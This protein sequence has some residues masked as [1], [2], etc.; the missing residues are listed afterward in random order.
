MLYSS[1]C[2]ESELLPVIPFA[3]QPFYFEE[4]VCA[5]GGSKSE[6]VCGE[7]LHIFTGIQVP[8]PGSGGEEFVNFAVV[9]KVKMTKDYDSG[10][11]GAP[12][13][14]PIQVPNSTQMIASPVGQ[15][16]ETLEQYKGTAQDKKI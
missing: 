14:I 6:M 12:V 5:F 16:V 9:V 3:S 4:E 10:Y 15:V 8:V 7:I 11:M 2:G 1:Q 13:Y